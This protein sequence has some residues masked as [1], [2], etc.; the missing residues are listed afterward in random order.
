MGDEGEDMRYVH[1]VCLGVH[2]MFSKPPPQSEAGPPVRGDA[3]L[4]HNSESLLVTLPLP[5]VHDTAASFK[6]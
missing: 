2:V 1:T 4:L 5:S 3:Q 6:L